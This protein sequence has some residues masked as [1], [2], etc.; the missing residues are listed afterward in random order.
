[1]KKI[2]IHTAEE[3]ESFGGELAQTI[4]VPYVVYLVGDLG[5]GKTTLVRGFLRELGYQK[6]VKSPTY[7]FVEE[8]NLQH[9]KIYH[10]DIKPENILINIDEGIPTVQII[11]FGFSRSKI[12][13]TRH[14][15]F[16]LKTPTG[17]G[18]YLTPERRP[19]FP[20]ISE[21]ENERCMELQDSYAAGMTILDAL[22]A[23]QST[24]EDFKRKRG[25][26]SEKIPAN[27]SRHYKTKYGP[28][29]VKQAFREK[30]LDKLYEIALEMTEEDPKKRITVKQAHVKLRRAMRTVQI[31]LKPTRPLPATPEANSQ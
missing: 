2:E 29:L 20:K 3:M 12:L 11:D 6:A 14:D 16:D 24:S 5:A 1:M 15:F 17:T 18:A 25:F 31:Q 8:Y 4:V 21:C 26:N 22:I 28:E 7:T 30:K 19:G 23:P 9:K 10:F 27:S 13:G